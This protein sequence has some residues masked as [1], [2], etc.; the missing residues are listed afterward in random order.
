VSRYAWVCFACR[1]AF[2]REAIDPSVRCAACGKPCSCLGTKVPIPRKTNRKAWD[3]LS[4]RYFRE[5]REYASLEHEYR[6]RRKHETEREIARLEALPPNAGR[7]VA[8]RELRK[9]LANF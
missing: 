7:K 5:K 6:V 4:E 2:R 3:M 9:K 8:I 1:A